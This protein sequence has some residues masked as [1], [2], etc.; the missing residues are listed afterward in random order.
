MRS[1][2]SPVARP[3]WYCS[4]MAGAASP[5]ATSVP[6]AKSPTANS[7]SETLAVSSRS[8]TE[9]RFVS[10]S[11]FTSSGA[12]AS[13]ACAERSNVAWAGSYATSPWSTRAW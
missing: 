4:A 1:S 13:S 6:D 5:G 12:P 3:P 7:A 9:N 11:R 8:G 10:T 2:A